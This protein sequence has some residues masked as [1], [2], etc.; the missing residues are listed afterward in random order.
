[1]NLFLRF[2]FMGAVC[3][4]PLVGCSDD[5]TEGTGPEPTSDFQFE[6]LEL[7]Q[8]SFKVKITPEDKNM[9]YFFGVLEKSDF[10]QF[11]NLESLQAAN[12][13]NIKA[14][15]E[16]NGVGVEEFLL[17]ALL[18]GEQ[19]WK[20]NSLFRRPIMSF[21]PMDYR[22]NWRFLRLSILMNSRHWSSSK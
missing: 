20:Y 19:E 17:E 4:L 6:T 18:K 16:A 9:T 2:L 14:L 1:M 13:E 5:D 22:P 3:L 21:T 8:G 7:T 11:E 10:S 12:I 15:A